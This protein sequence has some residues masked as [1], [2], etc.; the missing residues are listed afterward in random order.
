[1]K[2]VWWLDNTDPVSARKKIKS[3]KQKQCSEWEWLQFDEQVYESGIEAVRDLIQ[4]ITL[5]PM[6]MPGRMM[7]CYGIPFD[8]DKKSAEMLINALEDIADN[9]VFL[10]I[11]RPDKTSAMY[12]AFQKMAAKDAGIVDEA[13]ELT[14]DN[15]VAWI[16]SRAKDVG[17]TIDKLACQI[18]TDMCDFDP[19]AVCAELAKLRYATQDRHVSAAIVETYCNGYGSA[20]VFSLGGLILKGDGE[21]AHELL[22]RLIDKGESPIK[23]CGLLQDWAQK[24]ALAASCKCDIEVLKERLANVKK[25]QKEP[26]KDNGVSRTERV[27]NDSWGWF[28]RYKGESVPMYSNPSALFY[29]CKDLAAAKKPPFWAYDALKKLGRLQI[30]LRRK[31][32]EHDK[33]MHLFIDSLITGA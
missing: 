30:E 25:W 14:K 7:Y 5:P 32:V 9:V 22:Q 21:G 10:V 29:P 6:F 17:V 15:A 31:N 1:M 33:L 20:N 26:E 2:K 23:I 28:V 3:V 4:G 11:A 12:K 24:I 8:K 19:G 27:C 18:L 16:E 13:F